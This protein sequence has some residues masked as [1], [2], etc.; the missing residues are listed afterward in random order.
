MFR[1]DQ[2]IGFAFDNMPTDLSEKRICE[3]RCF[4][5]LD[6]MNNWENAKYLLAEPDT[7]KKFTGYEVYGGFSVD[8]VQLDRT[9]S[10]ENWT[11]LV[12]ALSAGK[13]FVT[14]GEVLIKNFRIE[15]TEAVSAE[16]EWTFF[17]VPWPKPAWYT[18][19]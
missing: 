9:P 12:R 8:Y 19:I 10:V 2:W 4:G 18:F 15:G 5:V 16:V 3:K 7:Y 14:T 13:F 17:V 11:P 6:D 1:S